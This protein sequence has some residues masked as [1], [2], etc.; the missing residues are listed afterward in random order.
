MAHIQQPWELRL[1]IPRHART[2]GSRERLRALDDALAPEAAST[3]SYSLIRA[4]AR[5]QA[6]GLRNAEKGLRRERRNEALSAASAS[7][8]VQRVGHKP[9]FGDSFII[10][11]RLVLLGRHDWLPSVS[12]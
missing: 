7:P 5:L 12:V 6:W 11:N 10:G 4:A 8:T 1:E 3:A 2:S 9:G